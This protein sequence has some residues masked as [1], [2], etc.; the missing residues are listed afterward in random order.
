LQ[1]AELSFLIRISACRRFNRELCEVLTGDPHAAGHLA[2]FEAENLFLIPIDTADHEPWYRFHRLFSSF[3]N[4]RLDALGAAEVQALHRTA[5]RWFAS[6]SL[7]VEAMRHAQL[8]G[9]IDFVVELI[10]RDARRLVNTASFV[11]LLRWCDAVPQE[12]LQAR[13][14]A[15]LCAAWAQLSCSRV[16][17]FDRNIVAIEQHP[18]AH[19]P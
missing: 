17:D 16:A 7:H 14:N 10:D 12:R 9:D 11:E 13:L 5:S 15:C 3:L 6:R 1:P 19:E 18:Q 4:S 2:R 8:A